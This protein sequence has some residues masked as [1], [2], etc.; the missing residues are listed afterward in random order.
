M[1]YHLAGI[2]SDIDIN[3]AV[4]DC[5]GVGYAV[6]TTVNTLSRIKLNEKAKLYIS[7]YIKE[8]SFD[9][10]GFATLSEK[11]CFDMLLTVSGIGP[12]A[13]QAILSAATPEG[14]AI[15]IMNGDEKAITV[16]QGVG[17]KI[18]QRVILELKDKVSKEM[19][20]SSVELPVIHSP[21]DGDSR[22]EAVAALMVLGYSTP[23]INSALKGMDIS[24]MST[25]QI[26]K[27][28]LK[29]LM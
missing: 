8:D 24:G 25:E 5:G 1:F 10:Y 2:V 15:A 28:A 18:A 11:R 17:K 26:V 21:A 19:G 29:N 13:A 7:E 22:N 4:I 9:L 3:L 6:N 20:S 14:L 27:I 23:E 16:A 12:K